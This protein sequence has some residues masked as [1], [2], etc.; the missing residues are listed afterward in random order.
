MLTGKYSKWKKLEFSTD[1][2][3]DKCSM[4]R[5]NVCSHPINKLQNLHTLGKT[6]GS[7]GERNLSFV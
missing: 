6:Q 3:Q 1:K 5:E 7:F 4:N 2:K